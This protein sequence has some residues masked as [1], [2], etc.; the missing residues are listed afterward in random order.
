MIIVGVFFLIDLLREGSLRKI[1]PKYIILFGLVVIYFYEYMYITDK[2]SYNSD[3]YYE[4][5]EYIFRLMQECYSND[6]MIQPF[7][8]SFNKRECVVC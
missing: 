2:I 3:W 5:Q 8:Y 6:D 4:M 7:I 1:A